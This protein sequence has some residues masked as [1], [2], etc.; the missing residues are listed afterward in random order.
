M[1]PLSSLLLLLCLSSSLLAAERSELRLGPWEDDIGYRQ[2][3]RVGN[4]V[5]IS[6][7]VGAAPMQDGIKQA[8][9]SLAK[10]L[11]HFGLGFEHVV[12]ETVYTTDLDALKACKELRKPYYKT[13]YPAATWVQ[14]S[15]LFEPNYVIEIEV[16]AIIPEETTAKR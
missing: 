7:S 11:R 13:T 15:R 12:K 1:R 6:G 10:S 3:V 9:E 5:Y 14:V 8:Y 2:A 4:T 16:V